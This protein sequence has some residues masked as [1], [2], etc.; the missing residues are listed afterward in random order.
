TIRGYDIGIYYNFELLIGEFDL[1]Y[2]GAF[3]QE[4]KQVASSERA[5]AVLAA[6]AADP[7]IV[8]PLIGLGDLLGIDGNQEDEH[9][10]SV[11]WSK[12]DWGAGLSAKR[13]SEFDQILSNGA[14]FKIPSMT[15]YNAKVDYR[16][17][18]GD[19]D[20]RVRFGVNNFSD[21]RARIADDS[22][23]YFDDAHRDFGR[24][25]YFDLKADF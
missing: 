22:Y 6:K 4:Y 21:E 15:T 17:D 23:G 18:A 8:Y 3:Y 24:Y 13:I 5:L 10:A 25:Y 2:N 9:A 1:R 11:A 19:V 16:F 12:G 7:T 20:M 14:A